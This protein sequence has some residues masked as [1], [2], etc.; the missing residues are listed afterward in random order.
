M[1]KPKR[2]TVIGHVLLLVARDFCLAVRGSVRLVIQEP[3]AFDARQESRA[4]L[5]VRELA[6]IRPEVKF[7]QI[8]MQMGFRD[9]MEIAENAAL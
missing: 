9:A 5:A 4:T 2:W 8:P 6:R 1:S 7:G 3:L